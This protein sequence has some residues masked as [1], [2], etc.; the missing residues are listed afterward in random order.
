M[1]VQRM[2]VYNTNKALMMNFER[3]IDSSWD[4]LHDEPSVALAV[5]YYKIIR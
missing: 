1:H 4:L 5:M 2:H 3:V